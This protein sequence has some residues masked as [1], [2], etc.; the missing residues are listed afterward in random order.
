MGEKERLLEGPQISPARPSGKSSIK[1][2]NVWNQNFKVLTPPDDMKS[3]LSF[4]VYYY[5]CVGVVCSK[6][7]SFGLQGFRPYN[8]A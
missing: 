6:S 1:N 8:R 2:E 4:T 7:Q 3:L 5:C